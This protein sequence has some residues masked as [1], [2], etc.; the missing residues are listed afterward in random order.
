MRFGEGN[1]VKRR[2]PV[3]G[4]HD[5]GLVVEADAWDGTVEMLLFDADGPYTR[6]FSENHAEDLFEIVE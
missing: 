3:P 4:N 1:I 6:R 5:I 2:N